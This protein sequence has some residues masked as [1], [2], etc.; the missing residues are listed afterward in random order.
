MAVR[1][2]V[3]FDCVDANALAE[4]WMAALGYE[5]MPAPKGYADWEEWRIA[6]KLS[7]EEFDTGASIVDPEG[8]GPRITF[9][10]VPER[11]VAKNRMH[12]DLDITPDRRAP[13][14]ERKLLVDAEAE[15]L[16]ALGARRLWVGEQGDHYHITLADPE[17]NEFCL[18]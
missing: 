2:E 15:R 1:F 10:P 13:I 3:T 5:P 4:F 9:L 18:S 17:G 12:L 11:K 7:K 14:A 6:M 16:I 8:R